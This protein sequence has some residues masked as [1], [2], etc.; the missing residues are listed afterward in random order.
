MKISIYTKIESS[1]EKFV[2]SLIK[3]ATICLINYIN[4]EVSLMT[5]LKIFRTILKTR[6]R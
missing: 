6:V 2:S 1:S 5:N 4:K 3:E